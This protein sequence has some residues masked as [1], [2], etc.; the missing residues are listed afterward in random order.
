MSISRLSAPLL[1]QK[2]RRECTNRLGCDATSL[3]TRSTADFVRISLQDSAIQA[4]TDIIHATLIRAD[5]RQGRTPHW[6]AGGPAGCSPVNAGPPIPA[7]YADEPALS[8]SAAGRSAAA[9]SDGGSSVL[10]ES[11]VVWNI[12][13]ITSTRASRSSTAGP[14][15]YREMT[16]SI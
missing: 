1:P 2:D 9:A 6:V 3:P 13:S 11:R 16:S 4:R 7:T 15:R 10:I 14:I 8:R 5:L 12:L